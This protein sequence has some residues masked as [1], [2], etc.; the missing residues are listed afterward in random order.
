MASDEQQFYQ[1]LE[2][3]MSL[4]NNTRQDAEV[5]ILNTNNKKK[6]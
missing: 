4:D 1:L 5:H 2:S 6:T 3:L